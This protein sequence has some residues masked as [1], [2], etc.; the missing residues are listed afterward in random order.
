MSR[1]PFTIAFD[2]ENPVFRL[3]LRADLFTTSAWR[4]IW[5]H[6][7]PNYELWV[8]FGKEPDSSGEDEWVIRFTLRLLDGFPR[9]PG[10]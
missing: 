2:G 9:A 3:P 6:A 4:G 5:L 1:R 8:N 10:A 7:T